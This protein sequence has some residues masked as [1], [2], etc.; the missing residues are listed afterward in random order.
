MSI[1][2][3]SITAE[4]AAAALRAT[5]GAAAHPGRVHVFC[6]MIGADWT[7]QGALDLIADNHRIAWVDHPLGHDLA[8]EIPSGKTYHL[9]VARPAAETTPQPPTALHP[10]LYPI[11]NAVQAALA[12]AL[13]DTGA[14]PAD[15]PRPLLADMSPR[16][17]RRLAAL[18][19]SITTQIVKVHLYAR[20]LSLRDTMRADQD[21]DQPVGC[22]TGLEVA[23]GLIHAYASAAEPAASPAASTW[24]AIAPALAATAEV[25]DA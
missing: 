7:L 17:R 15:P 1:R 4:T 3:Q 18:A 14:E 10:D 12:E 2:P 8:V 20:V 21:P 11:M 9:D 19:V 5:P 24:D 13:P 22:V 6:G 16:D 25:P 23:A